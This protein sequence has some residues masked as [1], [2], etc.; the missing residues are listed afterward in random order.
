VTRWQLASSCSPTARQQL[1][2]S[3]PAAC[4]WLAGG[5]QRNTPAAAGDVWDH[6]HVLTP[7]G[8]RYELRL[9][10]LLTAGARSR[11]G[12]QPCRR[13]GGCFEAADAVVRR[14][15]AFRGAWHHPG[16]VS[17]LILGT[18]G[19]TA[20]CTLTVRKSG[21]LAPAA[22]LAAEAARTMALTAAGLRGIPGWAGRS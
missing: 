15:K 9:F 5:A 10:G 1:A 4:Q 6:K 20:T 17:Q 7:E 3:S 22:A 19:S 18:V 8:G 11:H 14:H 13:C 16:C 12:P 21:E 2:G